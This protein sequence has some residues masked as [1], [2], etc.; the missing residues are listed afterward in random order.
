MIPPSTVQWCNC[1]VTTVPETG[2]AWRI[3][4]QFL[5]IR[6]RLHSDLGKAVRLSHPRIDKLWQT[7][8]ILATAQGGITPQPRSMAAF[9]FQAMVDDGGIIFFFGRLL[10][11]G[12][13][14]KDINRY[15]LLES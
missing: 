5:P 4:P 2:H 8:Q 1:A 6:H 9:P 10:A 7:A 14:W 12:K 13:N 15:Y 11:V 3:N